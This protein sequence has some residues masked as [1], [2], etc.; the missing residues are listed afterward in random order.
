MKRHPTFASSDISV[1]ARSKSSVARIG[2]DAVLIVVAGNRRPVHTVAITVG[3][4]AV[5]S[6]ED[7]ILLHRLQY[8]RQ[9]VVLICCDS[10]CRFSYRDDA[11]ELIVGEGGGVSAVPL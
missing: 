2:L 10:I 3:I 8:S 9:L 4:E 7:A 11:A 6:D 5:T 1:L